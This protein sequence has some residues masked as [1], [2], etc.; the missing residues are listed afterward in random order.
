MKAI[1]KK[2]P[3]KMRKKQT[4]WARIYLAAERGTGV[5]LSWDDIKFMALDDAI[6]MRGE[7]DYKDDEFLSDEAY[8]KPDSNLQECK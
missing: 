7:M 4:P 8:P 1:T 3:R 2:G 5:R 6:M